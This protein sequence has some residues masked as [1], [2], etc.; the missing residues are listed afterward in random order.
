MIKEQKIN[1]LTDQ[2]VPIKTQSKGI[3]KRYKIMP[4][5]NNMD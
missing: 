4:Y 5:M 3:A 1:D 2:S